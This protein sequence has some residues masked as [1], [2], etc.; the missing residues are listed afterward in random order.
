MKQKNC[1]VC[2][3]ELTGYKKRFCCDTCYQQY[4]RDSA[5]RRYEACKIKYPEVECSVCKIKFFPMRLNVTACSR[6]CSM[7][8]SA[9]RQK[10]KKAKWKKFKPERPFQMKQL[11]GIKQDFTKFDRVDSA[12]FNSSDTTKDAVMEYLEKGNTILKFPDSPRP[13]IPSVNIVNG[14]SIETKMGFGLEFEY[15]DTF[16]NAMYSH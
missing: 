8:Q 16:Y 15:D 13:K 12:Q 9:K 10:A 5:K 6:S 2:N 7:I 1:V 11:Q 14:H 3:D 4:K